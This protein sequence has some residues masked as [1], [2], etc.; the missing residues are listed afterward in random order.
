MP[1][2]KDSRYSFYNVKQKHKKNIVRTLHYLTDSTYIIKEDI[3]NGSDN[4]YYRIKAYEDESEFIKNSIV[5]KKNIAAI[6]LTNYSLVMGEI[7]S[8]EINISAKK[9][10]ALKDFINNYTLL[11]D[12]TEDDSKKST[13]LFNPS[14]KEEYLTLITYNLNTL[15]TSKTSKKY[16]QKIYNQLHSRILFRHFPNLYTN[17]APIMINGKKIKHQLIDELYE[18]EVIADFIY[19]YKWLYDEP[20]LKELQKRKIQYDKDNKDREKYLVSVRDLDVING[21]YRFGMLLN[22]DDKLYRDSINILTH[23]ANSLLEIHG[24]YNYIGL[25]LEYE[26]SDEA[27]KWYDYELQEELEN[28]NMDAEDI[29]LEYIKEYNENNDG[30]YDIIY[31]AVSGKDDIEY[32]DELEHDTLAFDKQWE[33]T[34]KI[35][36][37]GLSSNDV[38]IN[39]Y[40]HVIS[41]SNNLHIQYFN[42]L[43]N[44]PNFFSK[45]GKVCRNKYYRSIDKMIY[46][47]IKINNKEADDKA[48]HDIKF[49]LMKIKRAKWEYLYTL[50]NDPFIKSLE[51]FHLDSLEFFH[52][53][54]SIF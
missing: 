20:I 38:T 19:R 17:P 41:H 27:D 16:V 40:L 12:T 52:M 6:N 25:D 44:N 2:N 32:E 9:L 53:D 48:I 24:Y 28:Y 21:F 37:S 3:G 43:V 49:K 42:L 35:L 23:G 7:D 26:V 15:K 30:K 11:K 51:D 4:S 45:T 54:D 50:V 31:E 34:F 1:K 36:Y 46:E 5:Y 47:Q 22:T 14:K 39:K 13:N 33:N 29:A 10:K 18:L 8:L